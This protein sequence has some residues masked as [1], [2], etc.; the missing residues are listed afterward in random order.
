M[1]VR[2]EKG[3]KRGRGGF[4]RGDDEREDREDRADFG[5]FSHLEEVCETRASSL[6]SGWLSDKL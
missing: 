6:R 3:Q 1:R 4:A 2:R 5:I